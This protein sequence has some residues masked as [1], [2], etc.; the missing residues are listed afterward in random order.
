[1]QREPD[2]QYLA[3]RARDGHLDAFEILAVRHRDRAYRVALRILGD[4]HDAEDATQ[5]ALIAAWQGLPNFA[6]DSAFSTW[7]YRIVV[8][9]CLNASRGRR[10]TRPLLDL[11]PPGGSRPEQVVEA[12]AQQTA[13]RQ[14]IAGLPF[15]QRAPLVLY[16]FEDFS[17]EQVA[18]I[19]NTT[20]TAVRGR[21]YRAR[22]ELLRAMRGWQ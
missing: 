16:Q 12:R 22:R 2:D 15:D 3:A 18:A 1:M 17:Y 14:A 21:I 7:L 19:L 9:R 20:P 11:D 5:D 4:P 8:N 6:G 13:L 10:P